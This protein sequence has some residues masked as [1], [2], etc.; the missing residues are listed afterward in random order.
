ML[1][2]ACRE[3]CES[4]A[5]EFSAHGEIMAALENEGRKT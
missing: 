5:L 4:K 2:S 1:C 3:V